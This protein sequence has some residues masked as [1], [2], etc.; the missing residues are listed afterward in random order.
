LGGKQFDLDPLAAFCS[1]YAAKTGKE[2]GGGLCGDQK[3]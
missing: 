3:K 1:D 2:G